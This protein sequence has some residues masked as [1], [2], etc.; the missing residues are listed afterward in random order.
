MSS[1]SFIPCSL[2]KSSVW[3]CEC[4][5]PVLIHITQKR[6]IIKFL[7][8][9]CLHDK[10]GMANPPIGPDNHSPVKS[11]QSTSSVFF[12][13][14]LQ[15]C[16]VSNFFFF[17]CE[18]HKSS[19]NTHIGQCGVPGRLD[20]SHRRNHIQIQGSQVLREQSGIF[21]SCYHGF[22]KSLQYTAG[23]L[24]RVKTNWM[25]KGLQDHVFWHER[26]CYKSTNCSFIQVTGRC[27]N[28]TNSLMEPS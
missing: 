7:T 1:S 15:L 23:P 10:A 17:T 25:D 4:A 8:F 26:G 22:L 14:E 12:L 5:I 9:S 24:S 19:S 3:R 16:L 13:A 27:I 18:A 2:F 20:I 21:I 28:I 11:L 6:A